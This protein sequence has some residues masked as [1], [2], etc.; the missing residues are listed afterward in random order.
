M[1]KFTLQFIDVT[2]SYTVSECDKI[3]QTGKE[4]FNDLTP[5]SSTY[6]TRKPTTFQLGRLGF[7]KVKEGKERAKRKCSSYVPL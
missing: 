4:I 3:A 1:F 6:P 7:I 5:S 2:R